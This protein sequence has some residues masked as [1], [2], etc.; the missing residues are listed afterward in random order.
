[1]PLLTLRDLTVR[2]RGPP[3]LD[4]VSCLIEPGQKIGLLGRNG[5]GKSSVIKA[6]HAALTARGVAPEAIHVGQQKSEIRIDLGDVTVRRC[7]VND[8][9]RPTKRATWVSPC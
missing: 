6:V 2:F 5:S 3:L 1:M 4:E 9:P 7:T 8:P